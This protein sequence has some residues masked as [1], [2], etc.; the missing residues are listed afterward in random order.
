MRTNKPVDLGVKYSA[1]D[2]DRLGDNNALGV[3][4]DNYDQAPGLSENIASTP[5]GSKLVVFG[6]RT[7]EATLTQEELTAFVN[8][9]PWTN[10]PLSNSQIRLNNGAF[11]FSGNVKTRYVSNLIKTLYP[12]GNYGELSPLLK[13]AAH[14]QNPAL[15]TK[16]SV[17]VD[18][19]AGGPAHGH[20]HLKVLALKVDRTDLSK[21]VSK[22]NAIDMNV[23]EASWA[24]GL[25]FSLGLLTISNGQLDVYGTIPTG[26]AVGDGDP[27]A[28]C[29]NYH[30]GPLLS[31]S[32]V[33][34]GISSVL[35]NCE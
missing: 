25:G 31:L 23:G 29:K 11:E 8:M 20:L 15:Y 26:F 9:I 12:T 16:M 1:E 27:G 18:N 4:V 35:K 28:I 10:S 6:A 19:E 2:F 30:G 14:L 13:L 24:R 34:G 5:P 21:D 33:N 7:N 17:S 32:P 22:M 3:V